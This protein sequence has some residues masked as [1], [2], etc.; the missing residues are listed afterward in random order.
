LPFKCNLQR[1]NEVTVGEEDG[2]SLPNKSHELP[3]VGLCT[4][5]SFDPWPITFQT[6]N[7]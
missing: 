5:N 4:L 7:L 1:Y 2:L 3:A 6:H